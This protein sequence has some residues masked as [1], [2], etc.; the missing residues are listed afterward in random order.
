MRVQRET[1]AHKAVF[2]V[3]INAK[4]VGER[5][6][7]AD[8]AVGQVPRDALGGMRAL[9]AELYL[10]LLQEPGALARSSPAQAQ[11]LLKVLLASPPVQ[12]LCMHAL[13]VLC[14]NCVTE[15]DD[16]DASSS[17]LAVGYMEHS[18]THRLPAITLCSVLPCMQSAAKLTE[19]RTE[20]AAAANMGAELRQPDQALLAGLDLQQPAMLAKGLDNE[21][22]MA[23]VEELLLSWHAAV[24]RALAQQ[25]PQQQAPDQAAQRPPG[26]VGA[27][28]PCCMHAND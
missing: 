18:L 25:Q 5:S 9:M 14:H 8:I 26:E 22:L 20:A 2:F 1:L 19:T 4:G 27:P 24:D 23:H 7:E 6:P 3:R 21:A 28:T 10:P 15:D 12:L 13:R 17:A 16:S 11:A